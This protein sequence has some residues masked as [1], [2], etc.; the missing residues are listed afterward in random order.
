MFRAVLAEL[1]SLRVPAEF[2]GFLAVFASRGNRAT[3]NKGKPAANLQTCTRV[4]LA[5]SRPARA[6]LCLR[7]RASAG[8]MLLQAAFVISASFSH[9][10]LR[11][12]CVTAVCQQP[13]PR[14]AVSAA[15]DA[16]NRCLVGRRLGGRVS[17]KQA[18]ADLPKGY[19]HG[20]THSTEENQ[21]AV[22][23][24]PGTRPPRPR[25]SSRTLRTSRTSEPCRILSIRTQVT[26]PR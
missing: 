18:V 9:A 15:A 22:K 25:C 7:R 26:R 2:R 17:R 24:E 13:E 1:S 21:T 10:A 23:D 11:Q 16:P 3:T 20:F 5:E 14:A 19:M 12:A 4:A 8:P 6:Q